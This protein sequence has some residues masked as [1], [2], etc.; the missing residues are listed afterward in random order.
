V[1]KEAPA[2]LAGDMHYGRRTNEIDGVE[3]SGKTF[4]I[5]C[6]IVLAV[7]FMA[8]YAVSG[9]VANFSDTDIE[10]GGSA[11]YSD[12][13]MAAD[14]AAW[15]SSD[16]IYG[17]WVSDED[18]DVLNFLMQHIDDVNTRIELHLF[19]GLMAN[20]ITFTEDGEAYCTYNGTEVNYSHFV[21][22]IEDDSTLKMQWDDAILSAKVDT[23]IGTISA[24]LGGD[25]EFDMEYELNGDGTLQLNLDGQ[26]IY[27]HR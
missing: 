11:G 18:F 14:T 19:A 9:G 8:F 10:T 15:A 26:D 21:Y 22:S 16:T 1:K 13:T 24:S 5:A 2:A 20:G 27:L 23:A 4:Y 3:E 6:V 7:M 12:T 25:S 17:D